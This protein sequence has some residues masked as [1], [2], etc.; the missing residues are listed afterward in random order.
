MKIAML[1]ITIFLKVLKKK[2]G[3]QA[4]NFF[5]FGTFSPLI[6]RS[7]PTFLPL[8]G[9]PDFLEH[10]PRNIMIVDMIRIDVK[11]LFFIN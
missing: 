4:L 5:A 2:H 3:D 8:L 7:A 10:D 11:I 6:S 9:Q 1:V